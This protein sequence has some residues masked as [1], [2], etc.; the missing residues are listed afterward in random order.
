MADRSVDEPDEKRVMAVSIRTE[1]KFSEPTSQPA[2]TS[3]RNESEPTPPFRK[4]SSI[5][6]DRCLSRAD[7]KLLTKI[8][9]CDDSAF[10]RNL[11]FLKRASC[12]VLSVRFSEKNKGPRNTFD[13]RG[14]D[15][16]ATSRVNISFIMVVQSEW[17]VDTSSDWI[18]KNDHFG[19]SPPTTS[20]ETYFW[21]LSIGSVCKTRHVSFLGGFIMSRVSCV[22]TGPLP[23]IRAMALIL[24]RNAETPCFQNSL[25]SKC[26]N[27]GNTSCNESQ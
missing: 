2:Y 4:S 17:I 1:P 8:F 24:V 7:P 26:D 11:S 15:A 27:N 20:V 14:R 18:S 19:T 3:R 6:S 23:M 12:L 13:F 10:V 16:R 5:V 9:P 21:P 22:G 25:R